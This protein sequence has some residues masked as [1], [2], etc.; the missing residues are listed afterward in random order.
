[1]PRNALTAAPPDERLARLAGGLRAAGERLGAFF[2]GGRAEPPGFAVF[3]LLDFC[4]AFAERDDPVLAPFRAVLRPL[5]VE[6][7]A[8]PLR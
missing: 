8:M 1:M 5:V 4:P 6:P 2:A 3:V 7:L